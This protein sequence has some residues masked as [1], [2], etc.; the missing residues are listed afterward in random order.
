M[1][2]VSVMIE[3]SKIQAPP[4]QQWSY[5]SVLDMKEILRRLDAIDK[6]LEL[7]DCFDPT[8]QEFMKQLDERLKVL[9]AERGKLPQGF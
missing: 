3:T 8:K 4:V 5:E 2:F 9:E 1:C 7:K 6:K